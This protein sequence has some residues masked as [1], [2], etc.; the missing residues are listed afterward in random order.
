MAWR[1]IMLAV[2]LLGWATP[3]SATCTVS[4]TYVRPTNFELVR[5]ADAIV[6]ATP[7]AMVGHNAIRFRV[8]QVVKGA[9]P[10]EVV[11]GWMVLSEEVPP[12]SDLDVLSTAHPQVSRPCYRRAFAD[13]ARYLLLIGGGGGPDSWYLD[14]LP[15]A[16]NAEDYRG[17]DTPWQRTVRR[18]VALQQRLA[19][20]AQREALR[21]M[22]ASGRALDGTPLTAPELADVRDH[23]SRSH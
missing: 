20:A 13:G 3:S 10:S 6:V 12:P 22:L 23:L 7:V 15:F 9:P 5:R 8:E 11:L 18:Y 16:R 21:A 14:I 19:P 1:L 4:P 2:A 17:E